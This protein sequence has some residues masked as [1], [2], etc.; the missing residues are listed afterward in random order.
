MS[1]IN[2]WAVFGLFAAVPLVCGCQKQP[3]LHPT[4]EHPATVEHVEGSEVSRVTLS[5]K[6]MQ[7][8]DVQTG[9]VTEETSPRT[10]AAQ[11]AV[12]HSAIIYDP[13]GNTWVYT[14]PEPR[15]FVREQIDVDYIQGGLAYLSNGPM[16][17]TNIAT[18]GVAELYGTE[19]TVGH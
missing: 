9:M 16:P 12:P 18:V 15:V 6:A 11:T 13:N 14:S 2:P 4:H 8:L 17:G 5:E 1:S 3:D 19:F 10:E 7:R